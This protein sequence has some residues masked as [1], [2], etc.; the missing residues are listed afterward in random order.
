VIHIGQANATVDKPLEHLMACHRRIEER[1]VTLERAADHLR[2]DRCTALEAI[3]KSI[4]FL[5]SSG[6]L[7]TM[8]EEESLFP[9]M[10][11]R[12]TPAEL[13]YLNSLE[14]QHRAAE[15]V[16]TELNEVAEELAVAGND[17]TS[18]ESHYK[19]LAARLSALYRPHIQSEEEILTRLARRTLTD[20]QLEAI[21]EEMKERREQRQHPP[22][23]TVQNAD[24]SDAAAGDNRSEATPS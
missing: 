2:A 8:D 18:L 9:R 21:A 12:L 19:E 10:R 17:A 1:L 24:S 16:F 4:L 20:D 11:P 14:E 7:H 13:H 23:L 6:V 15:S 22:T 5:E 3:R